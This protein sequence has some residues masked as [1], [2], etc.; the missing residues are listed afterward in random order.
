MVRRQILAL[1]ALASAAPVLAQQAPP[2]PTS[3]PDI[4]VTGISLKDAQAALARCL[5][6]RCPPDRDIAATLAVAETQFVAGDYKAARAVMA[7]SIGRNQRFAKTY[8][9]PVSD[10]LR[11]NSRVAVHLGEAESYRSGALDVVSALK[12]GLPETDPRVL[13]A[14]VELGDAFLKTGQSDSALDMYKKVARQAHDLHLG[15]VE[16]YALLRVASAYSAISRTRND[17]YYVSAIKAC[18]TVVALTD[19]AA[20]PFVGAAKLLKAK[21]GVKNGDPDA[22]DRLIDTYRALAVG[23]TSPVLLYAPEIKQ[24]DLSGM[25]SGSGETLGKM[26]MGDFDGQWV[27]IGFEVGADGKVST[28]E[29]LRQSP[30]LSGDWIK[31]VLTAI[32]G[33]RYAPLGAGS[34]SAPRVERYTY[35]ATWTT[36][37]GSR[38]RVRSPI[39]KIEILDL[40][41]EEPAAKAP[42]ADA[43]PG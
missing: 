33:R 40:S 26:A 8:P 14:R 12:A 1:I 22:I 13:D 36:Y 6:Q 11:A 43:K 15:H 20:A 24:P 30:K 39:P 25:E 27:D 35:T 29:V 21:L 18:D 19:P 7:K 4:V 2:V 42:P 38:M 5:E 32:N 34:Q 41:R 28:A 17:G 16:G 31:P 10:L 23:A 37:V 3:G 9:V